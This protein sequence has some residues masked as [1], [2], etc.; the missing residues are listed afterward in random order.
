MWLAVWIDCRTSI[1]DPNT[2]AN[3]QTGCHGHA[4]QFLDVGHKIGISF[5]G[6]TEQ[7]HINS[8]EIQKNSDLIEEI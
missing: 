7:I 3:G 2:P 4:M 6:N 5:L 1:L 8:D